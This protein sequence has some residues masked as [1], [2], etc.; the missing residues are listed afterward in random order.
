MH[1]V[2]DSPDY[3]IFTKLQKSIA[4]IALLLATWISFFKS[5]IFLEGWEN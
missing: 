1:F 2:K 4:L 5:G 3:I